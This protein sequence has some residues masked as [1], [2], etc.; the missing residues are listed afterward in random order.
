[1]LSGLRGKKQTI[2]AFRAIDLK[3]SKGLVI[4]FDDGPRRIV[5]VNGCLLANAFWTAA[6]DPENFPP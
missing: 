6:R 5:L 4:Q 1:M 2:V 3:W